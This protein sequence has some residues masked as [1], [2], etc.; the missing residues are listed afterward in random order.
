MAPEG[1][2]RT[3]RVWPFCCVEDDY[4]FFR[5]TLRVLLKSILVYQVS[6]LPPP[7]AAL[8]AEESLCALVVFQI[9]FWA[10]RKHQRYLCC[11]PSSVTWSLSWHEF[12]VCQVCSVG[13]TRRICLILKT[14]P[15]GT[16]WVNISSSQMR[17]LRY[18][19]IDPSS[20]PRRHYSGMQTC[21]LYVE[22]CISMCPACP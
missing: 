6:P 19:K 9:A 8:G 21:S 5:I 15:L 2:H 12:T 10:F 4:L 16:L 17:K 20:P 7:G 22:L 3:S 18:R 13:F 1:L 14:V 11:G